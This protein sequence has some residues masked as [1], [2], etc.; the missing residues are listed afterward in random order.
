MITRHHI[1]LACGG[2]LILYLPLVSDNPFVLPVIVAG[3][4]IGAVLPDIQMKKPRRFTALSPVWFL[5]QV[6]KKTVLRIYISLCSGM[7]GMQPGSRR[8]AAD[9]FAPRP[10]FFDRAYRIW[11][12]PVYG[13]IPCQP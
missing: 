9:P 10:V 3:V 12:R 8:Q 6:F 4:C 1:C 11:R 2:T 13:S 5:V 7:C